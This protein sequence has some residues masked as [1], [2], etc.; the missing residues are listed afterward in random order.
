MS[1][2]QPS[3]TAQELPRLPQLPEDS[4]SESSLDLRLDAILTSSPEDQ[5]TPKLR[6]DHSFKRHGKKTLKNTSL[7]SPSLSDPSHSTNEKVSDMDVDNISEIDLFSGGLAQSGANLDEDS[8]F[9]FRIPSSNRMRKKHPSPSK[10][11]LERLSRALDYTDINNLHAR[12]SKTNNSLT[13][14]SEFLHTSNNVR[15]LAPRDRNQMVHEIHGRPTKAEAFNL[16][17]KAKLTRG[18]ASVPA[19]NSQPKNQRLSMIPITFARNGIDES[20]MNIDELQME[21]SDI[22]M[23]RY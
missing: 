2:D 18:A 19:I 3:D 1:A 22:A 10:A 16:F 21:G 13:P 23:R 9:I 20:I 15:I 17:Q 8:N 12:V 14:H 7:V 11:E 5:S 6:R 4:N